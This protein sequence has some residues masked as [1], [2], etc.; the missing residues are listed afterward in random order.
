VRG[1]RVGRA[2][3]EIARLLNG[4]HKPIY[5]HALDVGDHVVVINSRHVEF[6]GKKWQ[7]KFYRWHTG[8]PGIQEHKAKEYHKLYPTK[9]LE[10]AVFG[11]LGQNT[12]LRRH[13]KS[14]LRI[15]P[16]DDHPH[17][18]QYPTPYAMKNTKGA[19]LT[20]AW[21]QGIPQYKMT[22]ERKPDPDDP[23]KMGPW[24]LETE[25]PN[26]SKA[27]MRKLNGKKRAGLLSAVHSRKP[28]PDGYIRG[29][30]PSHGRKF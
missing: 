19:D 4:K 8:Y 12:T 29:G 1:Q 25:Q 28:H 16:D 15:F 30:F 9:V 22:F 14:R 3:T 26:V 17:A 21:D 20:A 13:R 27:A 24:T 10:R 18:A 23:T 11:M 2:A 5:N 6:T 7:Q